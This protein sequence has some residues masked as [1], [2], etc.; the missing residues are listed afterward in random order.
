M[1]GR[2]IA[3]V[4][5]AIAMALGV[6]CERS[7]DSPPVPKAVDR[8][9]LIAFNQQKAAQERSLIDSIAAVRRIDALP[10]YQELKTG[11]RIWSSQ[12]LERERSTL[13]TGDTVSWTGTMMLLDSTVLMNWSDANPFQFYWNR[14]D[15]PAGFHE[16]ARHLQSGQ[17][18][19]CIVPSH[20]GWGLSGWPPLIPQD[21][22]L[23][24]NI[25]QTSPNAPFDAAPSISR[26]TWN[27][28]LDAL[29]G[30]AWPGDANWIVEKNLA[31]SPCMAWYDSSD[32]M[33][34]ETVPDRIHIDLRTLHMTEV[35]K[36]VVDLGLTSW[37]YPSDASGQLLPVLADLHRL[38]PLPRKWACWCPV[39]VVFD[40]AASDALGLMPNGVVGFQWELS[41]SDSLS[42]L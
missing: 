13:Q 27:G 42:A 32:S 9:S 25:K 11:L 3:V 34:F 5:I 26:S 1:R 19:E 40:R 22:V 14:S 29:E 39:D 17:Q 24:L 33:H 35:D 37:D 8:A 20:M 7:H 6:G 23:W 31:A 41:A 28:V 15:W 12:P 10:F 21:A 36:E 38:Y 4:A 30:G 2:C 16:L 18:A